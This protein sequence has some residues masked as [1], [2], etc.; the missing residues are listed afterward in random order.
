MLN[1][2]IFYHQVTRKL[3][4]GF[5]SLFSNIKLER[6]DKEGLT[7]Q[8]IA[9]PIT[10]SPKEK[11]LVR[12][13]QDPTLENHTYITLPRLAF[14][15]T[16]INYDSSR[17]T[18]RGGMITCGDANGLTRTFAP[19]PYNIDI[20]LYA[21]TKTTEDGLQIVEQILPFFTPELTMSIKTIPEMNVTTDVPI[22]LN[23]VSVNDEYDGDFQTRR[24]V[25]WTF[26]FTLKANFFG[27]VSGG[28]IIKK[29]F[30]DIN[31]FDTGNIMQEYNAIG[32]E[33]DGSITEE[34]INH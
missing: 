23:G 11:W 20:S 19:T 10:Y 7:Q 4:V 3:I 32:N 22:I 16:G 17:K 34:W 9:V 1:N 29:V 24:F 18:A 8:T 21:L 27:P 28:S 30:V 2:S 15:I 6:K 25:T 13:E 26:N 14:E 12:V 5:G 33:T 31:N